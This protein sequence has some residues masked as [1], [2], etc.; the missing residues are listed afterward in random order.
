MNEN[1]TPVPKWM[2]NFGIGYRNDSVDYL[3]QCFNVT[4]DDSLYQN[5]V[6]REL[7]RRDIT[8]S[9]IECVVDISNL[10]NGFHSLKVKPKNISEE[11]LNAIFRRKEFPD[12]PFWK[13]VY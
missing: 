6:W 12:I 3:D 13:D 9:G 8:N 10:K 2:D 7:K 11:H 1:R 4:V 5:L